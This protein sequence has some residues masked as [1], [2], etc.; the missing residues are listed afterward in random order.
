MSAPFLIIDGYNLLHAAGLAK[1]R[2]GPGDL[3]RCRERLL[4][5]L[6]KHLRPEQI[7]R[8]TVVFDATQPPP[9]APRE[10]YVQG[11]AVHFATAPGDADE[12]IERWLQQHPSSS[13]VTLISSDHRLQRAAKRRHAT[14]VDSEQFFEALLRHESSS[15]ATPLA[16]R[17]AVDPKTTR[18]LRPEEVDAWLAEF[19][20][21]PGADKLRSAIPFAVDDDANRSEAP[22]TSPA[23]E[24]SSSAASSHRPT[25]RGQTASRTQVDPEEERLLR[26]AE[27]C[28]RQQFGGKAPS[29][30]DD[31]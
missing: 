17:Q 6:L 18:R 5:L 29:A 15:G 3:Q 4:Q 8:A 10:Q 1:H 2:Y 25:P 27:D 22:T 30:D 28:L 26:E 11:L 19:G 31:F 20:D 16:R 13:H 12:F 9:D 24:T 7:A 23:L 14:P 21:I